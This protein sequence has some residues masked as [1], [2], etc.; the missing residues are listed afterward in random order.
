[1]TYQALVAVTV[2]VESDGVSGLIRC[3]KSQR[4]IV[5]ASGAL[6]LGGLDRDGEVYGC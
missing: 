5:S 3:Q 2:S 6:A 1:M 4:R